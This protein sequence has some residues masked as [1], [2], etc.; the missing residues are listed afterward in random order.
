MTKAK[1]WQESLARLSNPVSVDEY[2]KK[3]NITPGYVQRLCRIGKLR[4]VKINATWFIETVERKD[5][6][7][8]KESSRGQ[9]SQ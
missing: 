3:K 6:Q 5:T 7:R 8:V 2:A 4:C 1:Q 9:V